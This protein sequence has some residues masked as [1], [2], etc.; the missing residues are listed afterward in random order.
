MIKVGIIGEIGSGKSFI[1]KQFGCPVFDADQEVSK[2]YKKDR[3][4]FKR[5]KRE[6]PKYISSFPI[7]KNELEKAI[8]DQQNNIKKIVKIVHP[9]VRV[10]MNK[11]LKKNKNKKIVILDVPLLLEKKINK[12][13]YILIFVDAKKKD[14]FRRL[15]K[16]KNYNP[17][18]FNKLKKLQFFLDFKKRKSNYVIKNDFKSLSV[19]K[20]V[21]V[22]KNQLLSQ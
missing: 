15:V 11:F 18:I 16:R 4:C 20:S 17:K 6:L 14:I 2:I 19:K 3:V 5:L 12:K 22:L 9:L 10:S 1:A 13:N 7:K 21:K 8:L